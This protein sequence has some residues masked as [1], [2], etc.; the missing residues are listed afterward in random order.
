MQYQACPKESWC[1]CYKLGPQRDGAQLT[2]TPTSAAVSNFN[3]GAL[4]TYQIEFPYG[5]KS[6]DQLQ[7]EV[8]SMTSVNSKFI[9]SES[10][11]SSSYQSV[12]M[13]TKNLYSIGFPNKIFITVES[14]SP[15]TTGDFV[16]KA[17]YSID[18]DPQ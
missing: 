3:N 10:Y 16:M 17:K 7:V 8:L 1:G 4:C 6:G 2:M 13:N 14:T 11:S 18:A 9:V 15:D 5:S 12:D